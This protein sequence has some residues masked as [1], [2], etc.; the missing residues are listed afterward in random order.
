[1]KGLIFCILVGVGVGSLYVGCNSMGVKPEEISVKVSRESPSGDC[2]DLGDVYGTSNKIRSTSEEG[3]EDL[4]MDA[5]RKG[6]NYVQIETFSAMGS[7]AK[8]RAFY[9]R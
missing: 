3:L 7:N 4:K 8:G 6:A 2:K 5:S 1:M 9:C